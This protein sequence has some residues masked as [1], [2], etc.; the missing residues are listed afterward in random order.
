MGMVLWQGSHGLAHTF[1]RHKQQRGLRFGRDHW[2]VHK[3]SG[4]DASFL[5]G[6]QIQRAATI[7][8]DLAF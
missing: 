8:V 2:F 7:V 4:I 5:P 1:V 3:P 6:V